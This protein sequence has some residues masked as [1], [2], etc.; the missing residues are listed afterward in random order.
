MSLVCLNHRDQSY[1][2]ELQFQENRCNPILITMRICWLK[3]SLQTYTMEFVITT[4]YSSYYYHP[5]TIKNTKA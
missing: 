1:I 3:V 2:F 4:L 5:F